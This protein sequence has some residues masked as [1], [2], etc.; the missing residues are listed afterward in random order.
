MS[1]YTTLQSNYIPGFGVTKTEAEGIVHGPEALQRGLDMGDI[2]LDEEGFYTF[3][4]KIQNHIVGL[5]ED[6]R[7][8]AGGYQKL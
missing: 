7:I 5:S 8:E 1:M 2:L 3:K 6:N 4:R